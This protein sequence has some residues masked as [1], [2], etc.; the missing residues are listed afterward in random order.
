M[1]SYGLRLVKRLYAGR[2]SRRRPAGSGT[3]SLSMPRQQRITPEKLALAA[4]EAR[5]DLQIG[6]NPYAVPVK[7]EGL[8]HSPSFCLKI[9][10]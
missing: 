9:K 5:T 6:Q 8:A 4:Q 1:N 10:A 3:R 7:P 2:T